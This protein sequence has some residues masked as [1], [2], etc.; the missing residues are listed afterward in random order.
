MRLLGIE[1][2]NI[3]GP[4][5][6]LQP[7]RRRRSIRC[8]QR[9][10]PTLRRK[11]APSTRGCVS[12]EIERTW[13]ENHTINLSGTFMADKPVAHIVADAFWLARKRIAVSAAATR[14]ADPYFFLA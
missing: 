6:L 14:V 8:D 10:W 3:V 7:G 9:Q 12:I 4:F 11:L 1:H 5:V 13:V 2:V